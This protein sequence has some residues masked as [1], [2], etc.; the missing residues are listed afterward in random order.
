MMQASKDHA[1]K[2]ETF[3]ARPAAVM[4][5]WTAPFHPLAGRT[6]SVKVGDLA[7][8]LLDVTLN[9]GENQLVENSELVERGKKFIKT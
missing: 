1:D 4:G 2:L 8:A 7:A 5:T 9:G 3:V 6:Y